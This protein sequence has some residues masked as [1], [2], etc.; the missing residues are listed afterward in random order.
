[1]VPKVSLKGKKKW[2][3]DLN[4]ERERLWRRL[5]G[6]GRKHKAMCFTAYLG[7][8]HYEYRRDIKQIRSGMTWAAESAGSTMEM[9]GLVVHTWKYK[10]AHNGREEDEK[11]EIEEKNKNRG[12]LMCSEKKLQC[13]KT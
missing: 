4:E 10:Y 9:H 3:K 2:E 1:M 12:G 8:G 11:R 7:L 13:K 6:E 5:E